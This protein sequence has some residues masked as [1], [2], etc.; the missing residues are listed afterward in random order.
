M[1]HIDLELQAST[2][3]ICRPGKQNGFQDN[4]RNDQSRGTATPSG[5]AGRIAQTMTA[6][7]S[8]PPRTG[9]EPSIPSPAVVRVVRLYLVFLFL[10][11]AASAPR[12]VRLGKD[13]GWGDWL[14]N[15][16][17]GFVRRGLP[18]EIF[19][20]AS[21]IMHLRDSYLIVA[22]GLLCYTLLFWYVLRCTRQMSWRWWTVF[23]LACPAGLA[24]PVISRSAYRKEVVLYVVLC[25]V[26]ARFRPVEQGRHLYVL[27]SIALSL[28]CVGMTLSH[29]PL[30]S[31]FPY[32]AAATLVCLGDL[33]R[34]LQVL[35]VP[36]VLTAAT[37]GI[38][39]RHIGNAEI[40]K[41]ICAS[42]GDPVTACS[43]AVTTLADKR[44]DALAD[45]HYYIVHYH[46]LRVYP[47]CIVL[48]VPPF[49][50]AFAILRR[51]PGARR[52]LAAVLI[53]AAISILLSIQLFRYGV[54]WGRWIS[55]HVVCLTLLLLALQRKYI[56]TPSAG[57]PAS[58]WR[59]RAILCLALVYA[60]VWNVPTNR[61][62]PMNGYLGL[63]KKAMHSNQYVKGGVNLVLPHI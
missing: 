53:C 30:V 24:F 50:A 40:V 16:R 15:Y 10:A 48:A 44:A 17:G 34:T 23:V 47:V 45:V 54:D 1:S 36:A 43:L 20:W 8:S 61:N 51:E 3:Q 62:E 41:R 7:S 11:I 60:L 18:G 9:Q 12:M 29:E 42:V 22:F 58:A 13:W 33:R 38:V 28:A 63:V 59:S 4:F 25:L 35:A 27:W 26:L 31:Y 39:L 37:M 21:R 14:M 46:Y 19:Y 32:L 6:A 2:F 52:D 5:L 57:S 55:A 49:L 56:Q